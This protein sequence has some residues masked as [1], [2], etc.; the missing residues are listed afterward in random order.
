MLLDRDRWR[1]IFRGFSKS[2]FRL[3]THQVYSMP[4]EREDFERFLA[5]LP[6]RPDD[7]HEWHERVRA[8]VAAGK[9][10]QRAKVVRR[11]LTDYTRYLLAEGIPENVKA[12]EDYRII[13]VRD[14]ET[15]LPDQDFW[16]FD[17]R[18]VVHLDYE[19]D[20]TQCGRELVDEPDLAKYLRWRDLALRRGVPFD[21][22]HA[23]S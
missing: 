18:V 17:D 15:G 3:E 16:L 5:G 4:D 23:G 10:I 21:E 13:E 1:E 19:P 7:N 22:W 2:A 6:A 9:T 11:P 12:G 8:Y 20:G 14:E